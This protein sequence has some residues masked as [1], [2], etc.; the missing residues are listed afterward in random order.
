MTKAAKFSFFQ[1]LEIDLRGQ[2]RWLDEFE[3]RVEIYW[4][5]TMLR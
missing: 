4:V 2:R 1:K 3:A 5:K